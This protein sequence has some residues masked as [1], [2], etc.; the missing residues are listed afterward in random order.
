MTISSINEIWTLIRFPPT[1]DWNLEFFWWFPLK[2]ITKLNWYLQLY[3]NAWVVLKKKLGKILLRQKQGLA[4]AAPKLRFIFFLEITKRDK[5]SG[6]VY[7]IRIFFYQNFN[8]VTNEEN[9]I[10]SFGVRKWNGN[11]AWGCISW[12]YLFIFNGKPNKLGRFA[13]ARN[14]SNF[15]LTILTFHFLCNCLLIN[16]L[17]D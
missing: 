11:L 13:F 2:Y 15:I 7:F 6:I 8:W 10:D 9:L 16:L 1:L 14:I 3:Y 17:F 5:L 4:W 12:S